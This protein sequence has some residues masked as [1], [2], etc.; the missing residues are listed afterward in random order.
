MCLVAFSWQN[1][2]EY[3]LVISANRDEFFER[4]TAPLH[5]WD[6]DI[7]AGK[8]LRGGGT[9][10][11][12]HPSG[13]W[14][15]LTNYRDFRKMGNGEISRGKLVQDFLEDSISPKDYLKEIEKEKNRYEGFNLLVSDGKGLFY[16][17][18]FGNGI[19]EVKPGIHGLSNGLLNDPWPKTEL[20]KMQLKEALEQDLS[21]SKLL[22]ILKSKQTYPLEKLPDT[23]APKDLEIAL[24]AQ[25]IRANG[26]YGTRSA[27][28]V[29]WNKNNHISIQERT[30]DWIESNFEDTSAQIQ[31]Y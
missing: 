23:G 30:F 9:W 31:T 14:S 19:Q 11:G 22:Q 24:S 21:N 25:L 16:F 27:S 5:T 17:S 4:P 3:P 28:S 29:L 26:N 13:R 6:N 10:M 1:H 8:D 15:F 7:I 2:S 18:N 20:A 12:F